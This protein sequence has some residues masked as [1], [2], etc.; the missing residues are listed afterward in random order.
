MAKIEILYNKKVIDKDIEEY[1]NALATNIQFSGSHVKKIVISSVKENEGKSTVSINIAK[2]LAELGKKVLL[3]D[4]DLRKSS[5]VARFRLEGKT[6]GLTSYLSGITGIENV[7]H[8]TDVPNLTILPAG[9]VPPNPTNLLQN[10]NFDLM[11]SAFEKYYDY[12]IVD[13]PPIGVVIDAAIV[14]KKCDASILVVE[15]GAIKRK[16]LKKAKEQ[17]EH[18]GAEFLGV[19]LNKLDMSAENYGAYGSYG[20][21]GNYGNYGKKK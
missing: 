15:S 21:Y 4:C 9:Q 12:I 1:Y 8:D 13:A 16:V 7:L 17:L 20:S 5:I 19:I 3:L 2:S 14:A 6:D 10:K 11:I 18:S